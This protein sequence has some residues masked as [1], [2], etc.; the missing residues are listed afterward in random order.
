MTDWIEDVGGAEVISPCGT[1]DYFI[2]VKESYNINDPMTWPG[3]LPTGNVDIICPS[4]L[5][6]WL[7]YNNVDIVFYDTCQNVIN[8][9]TI[10]GIIDT[11][12]PR[13]NCPQDT[14][15]FLQAEDCVTQYS[16][17]FEKNIFKP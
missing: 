17:L 4:S 13:V 2:A 7:A 3:E 15:L 14:T 1:I 11:L 6:G 5:K 12:E 8:F 9:S 16:L 10:V